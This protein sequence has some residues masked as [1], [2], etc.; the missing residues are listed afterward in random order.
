MNL[1]KYIYLAL[2]LGSLLSCTDD[3]N[4]VDFVLDENKIEVEAAGGVEK[5][6]LNASERWIAST[7]NPWI[8]ISPANGVGSVDCEF[9]IDSALTVEPRRGVVRIQN[10]VTNEE[11]ELVIEQAGFPYEITVAKSEVEVENYDRQENRYFDVVVKSNVDFD[12]ALPEDAE[13]LSNDD[14]KLS[15]DRGV[16]PREVK[17]RFKWKINT[18]NAERLAKVEFKPK[19]SVELSQQDVLNVK[20]EAADPIIPDTRSGDSIAILNIARS[21]GTLASWESS[22]PMDM[23]D[24]VTLWDETMDGC[25][26]DKVG[27]VKR[28]EFTMFNIKET[29]PFEV[30]YLTAADELYF[31]GNSNTFLLNIELGDDITELTQLRRLTIGSYGLISIPESF[32]KLENLEYLNLCANNFQKVPAVLKKENFPKLRALVLNANQRSVVRDLS[33]TTKTNIGGFSDEAS[34]PKHLLM[35]DKLDTLILSVNYLQGELPSLEDDPDFPTWT[36][37]EIESCDT[38]PRALIG[39]P[40]VL[41]TTKQLSINLN[42]LS[43]NIPFWLMYHPMLDWWAPYSLV[44]PQE[45]RAADGT[46]AGFDNEPASLRDYYYKEPFYVNKKLA[47]EVIEDEY[48]EN[49]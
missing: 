21:L 49:E 35:W 44:F 39:T 22:E 14:Y 41:P 11:Q 25:T 37:E 2:A 4:K 6:R 7:D 45:G 9:R 40:K 30:R 8:S 31:F 28:V 34:F 13:W 3:K 5:I 32:K 43:G 18:T 17:V 23:W 15:L 12:V 47:N 1:R 24:A 10:L 19:Q 42:R 26:P 29:L 27:R 36:A 20:Q 16:R 38:L 33:N 48:D 46:Q